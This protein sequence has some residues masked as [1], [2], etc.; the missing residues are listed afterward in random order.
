MGFSHYSP[1]TKAAKISAGWN[2]VVVQEKRILQ[3]WPLRELLDKAS[4]GNNLRVGR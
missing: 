2:K 3:N 4:G 1:R